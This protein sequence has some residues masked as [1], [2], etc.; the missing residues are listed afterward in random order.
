MKLMLTRIV[1]MVRI[2]EMIKL[3]I[4]IIKIENILFEIKICI[5]NNNLKFN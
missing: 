4:M 3:N 2:I 1:R 5:T